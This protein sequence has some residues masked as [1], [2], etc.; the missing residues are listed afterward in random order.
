MN[1]TTGAAT[2]NQNLPR[3]RFAQ[4]SSETIIV[5]SMVVR[6]TAHPKDIAPIDSLATA[7]MVQPIETD[8]AAI[9]EFRNPESR[10]GFVTSLVVSRP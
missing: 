4:E 2:K 5:E 1:G 8:S 9:Q 6:K 10:D 7:L 3:G